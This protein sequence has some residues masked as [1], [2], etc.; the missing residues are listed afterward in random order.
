MTLQTKKNALSNIPTDWQ[1]VLSP[2]IAMR[3][4]GYDGRTK[5]M[6][7]KRRR[8]IQWKAEEERNI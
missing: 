3:N 6:N 5:G 1:I 4:I 7:R 2:G 8:K